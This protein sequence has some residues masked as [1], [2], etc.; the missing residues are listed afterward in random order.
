MPV[1]TQKT[2]IIRFGEGK[3]NGVTTYILSD[4]L[5][6]ISSLQKDLG[7]YIDSDL[8]FANHI[9]YIITKARRLCGWVLRVF[10]TRKISVMLTVY[11]GVIR[12]ILEYASVIW[13][14]NALGQIRRLEKVQKWY[15]KRIAGL[16]SL[17]YNE[18]LQVLQLET[19]LSRRRYFDLLHVYKV[20]GN[21]RVRDQ[22]FQMQRDAQVMTLRG[23][24][25]AIHKLRAN[26][27]QR[28]QFFANR[29]IDDWNR[30][31]ATLISLASR[32]R[33]FSTA[34]QTYVFAYSFAL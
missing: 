7:V 21:S 22:M 11:K 16:H 10:Q 15:T 29:V 19:L 30:L 20:L 27:R 24:E 8:T 1:N 17:S 12:P 5:L 2:Q 26:T 25:F 34:L 32:P 28:R 3:T 9:E 33:A 4:T 14:P 13:N 31:P 18:R 23:H 6:E